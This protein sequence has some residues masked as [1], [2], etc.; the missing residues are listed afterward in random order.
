MNVGIFSL[1]RNVKIFKY[2][3]NRKDI[4]TVKVIFHNINMDTAGTLQINIRLQYQLIP[5]L[6]MNGLDLPLTDSN[7]LQLSVAG[8]FE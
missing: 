5:R 4:I 2:W 8:D 6:L 3:S 1:Y 7:H